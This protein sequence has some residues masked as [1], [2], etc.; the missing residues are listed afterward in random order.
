MGQL[1][2]TTTSRDF[3]LS[4]T[5]TTTTTPLLASSPWSSNLG[6]ESSA[7]G[8]GLEV[9]SFGLSISTIYLGSLIVMFL[10]AGVVH[11][12]E[13]LVLLYGRPCAETRAHS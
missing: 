13:F 1:L 5:T 4:S 9:G 3:S 2:P 10:I 7:A 6:G 12:N 11:I 8:D